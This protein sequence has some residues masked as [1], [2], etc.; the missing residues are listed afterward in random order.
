MPDFGHYRGPYG[1]VLNRIGVPE[2]HTTNVVGETVFDFRGVDT[3]GEEFILFGSVMGV[4][5]LLR[6]QTERP[7]PVAEEAGGE[8]LRVL[9]LLM[10]GPVLLVGLWLAAFGYSSPGGGFQGGVV[11]AASLI[12]VFVAWS[13]RAWNALTREPMLDPVE[14]LGAG[15]Y[16]VIGLVALLSGLPFL[17]NLLGPGKTGTIWSGGSIGFLNWASA[18]AVAAANLLLCTE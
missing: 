1:D 18:F 5:L 16:V 11:I 2:R 17:A 14:A 7:K 4:A 3:M 9:G 8:A 6:R 13:S 12:V 15:G 10:V